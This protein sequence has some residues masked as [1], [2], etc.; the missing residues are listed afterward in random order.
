VNKERI[1]IFGILDSLTGR[2]VELLNRLG[3][4]EICFFI[5]VNELPKI[6]AQYEHSVRPHNRTEFPIKNTI[7]GIEIFIGD[8]YLQKLRASQIESCFVLEDDQVLRS[9]IT[10]ML[11]RAGVTLLSYIDP[12][13]VLGGKNQ[14]GP[15]TIIF[16][17]CYL[18]YKT[19][20]QVGSVIQPG[21]LI[22]H[23]SVVGNFVNI[24]PRLTTGGFV[25]IE[26]FAQI[27]ISVEI[28]NRIVIGRSTV[29]GAGSLVLENCDP[30][31]LY[32]GRPAVFVRSI[33]QTS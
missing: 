29:I 31:S 17:N 24:N 19:D 11:N 20:T 28:V 21:T 22:E 3:T 8:D 25:K 7:F 9:Q 13:T 15:G 10:E 32:Y 6:D 2:L 1:A 12:S 30:R 16:P 18:G 33:S 23:H 5:S 27:N 26:D 4:Y 14:L